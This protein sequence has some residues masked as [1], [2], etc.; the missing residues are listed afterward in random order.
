MSSP[1]VTRRQ[2]Q[3]FATIEEIKAV[4]RD[5]M[6]REGTA[7]LNLRAVARQ[8]GMT[9]SALYR[10]F[11]SR[12]AILTELIKEAYDAVG[13]AVEQALDAA[14]RD[15]SASAMLAGVHTFRRWALDHPQEYALIY[16]TPVPGYEAPADETF[17]PAMRTNVALLGELVRAISE[18]MIT[19]PDTPL[20][21]SLRTAFQEVAD[22]DGKAAMDLPPG[23]WALACQFWVVLF[24]VINAEVFGH[25]PHPL[26]GASAEFFDFTMRRA[27]AVMGVHEEALAAAVSPTS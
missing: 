18:G 8:M 10:Y 14:P 3:H 22:D 15:R 7:S 6:A 5:L 1:A 20:P 27:M 16:G 17:A 19:L 24:G 2:R 9:P 23:V 11:P 12:E 25:L 13:E 21:D 4:A 26:Q